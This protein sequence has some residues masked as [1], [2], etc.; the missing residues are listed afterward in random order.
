MVH[1][2][3]TQAQQFTHVKYKLYE[4]VLLFIILVGS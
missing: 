3:S 4:K 1:P 2:S